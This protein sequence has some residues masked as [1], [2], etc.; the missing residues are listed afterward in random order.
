MIEFRSQIMKTSANNKPIKANK[1]ILNYKLNNG[2]VKVL[3]ELKVVEKT[4]ESV[5]KREGT[6]LKWV[7]RGNKNG[8]IDNK[9]IENIIGRSRE[10]AREVYSRKNKNPIITSA[11]K[12]R[13]KFSPEK[14]SS[15]IKFLQDKLSKNELIPGYLREDEVTF[16]NQII[17]NLGFLLE[18]HQS[19][20]KVITNLTEFQNRLS[21]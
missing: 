4:K 14:V 20:P 15:Q 19:L 12:S 13:E 9:L 10:S 6:Y 1:F 7:Y 3:E 21:K 18:L 17:I 5:N 2:L 16:Y 8:E 11:I